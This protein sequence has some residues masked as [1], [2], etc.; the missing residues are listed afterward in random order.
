[1]VIVAFITRN[2]ESE[3]MSILSTIER[4]NQEKDDLKIVQYFTNMNNLT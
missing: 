2:Y 1:M 3:C 4:Y